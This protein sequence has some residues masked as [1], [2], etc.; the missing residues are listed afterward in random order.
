LGVDKHVADITDD[1]AVSC[2]LKARGFSGVGSDFCGSVVVDSQADAGRNHS[3]SSSSTH[4]DRRHDVLHGVADSMVDRGH[5][6]G[7]AASR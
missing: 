2:E 6:V 7:S 5:F 3:G 1:S 4:H